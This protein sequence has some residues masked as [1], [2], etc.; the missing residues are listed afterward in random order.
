MDSLLS[1]VNACWQLVPVEFHYRGSINVEPI[2]VIMAHR[3]NLRTQALPH[4]G[5]YIWRTDKITTQLRTV[6]Q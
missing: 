1:Y 5:I 2:P 4:R 3:E 6:E